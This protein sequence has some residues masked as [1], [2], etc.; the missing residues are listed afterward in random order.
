MFSQTTEYALRAAVFLA[1]APDRSHTAQQ[2]AELTQVPRDYLAKVLRSLSR[3][4]LVLAQRGKHGGFSLTRPPEHITIYDVV[5]AVDP[6]PRI[7]SCPLN[8]RSHRKQLCPLHRKLDA[9]FATVERELRGATL[10]QMLAGGASE[11][12][13]L[14]EIEEIQEAAHA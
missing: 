12:R 11:V 5:E 3:A 4:G 6:L 2:I 1:D 10:A 7:R 9:A 14:C 8:L 13:P